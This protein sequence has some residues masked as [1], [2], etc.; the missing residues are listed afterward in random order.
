MHISEYMLLVL[1]GAGCHQLYTVCDMEEIT[2]SR[3]HHSILQLFYI[4]VLGCHAALCHL[5]DHAIAQH[6]RVQVG[7][8]K[9]H[10]IVYCTCTSITV[11]AAGH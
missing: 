7:Q 6:L 2:A 4:R 10:A 3:N 11:A 5:S 9:L 1:L 8:Y